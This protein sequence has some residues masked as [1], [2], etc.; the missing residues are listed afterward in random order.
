LLF[1]VNRESYIRHNPILNETEQAKQ[2]Q[3]YLND[4]FKLYPPEKNLA[5]TEVDLDKYFFLTLERKNHQL[6]IP[7]QKDVIKNE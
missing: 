3:A 1:R 2:D 7:R 4:D 6:L 5:S